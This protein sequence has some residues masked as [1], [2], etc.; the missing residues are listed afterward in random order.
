MK[1]Y[2]VPRREGWDCH[3]LPVENLIEKDWES[4]QEAD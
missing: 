3:G 2:Q 1:G 4:K